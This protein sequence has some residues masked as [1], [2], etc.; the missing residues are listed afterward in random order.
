MNRSLSFIYLILISFNLFSMDPSTSSLQESTAFQKDLNRILEKVWKA[1]EKYPGAYTKSQD[2]SKII[3]THH[4]GPDAWF[5]LYET[6]WQILNPLPDEPPAR[7]VT[8]RTTVDPN[9]III[10]PVSRH[11]ETERSRHAEDTSDIPPNVLYLSERLSDFEGQHKGKT[12]ERSSVIRRA[13]NTIKAHPEMASDFSPLSD[14]RRQ[15]LDEVS[16]SAHK[17]KFGSETRA[18]PPAH[19]SHRLQSLTIQPTPSI[20]HTPTATVVP[21]ATNPFPRPAP[22]QLQGSAMKPKPQVIRRPT[23]SS[24]GTE[25]TRT[26]EPSVSMT[27]APLSGTPEPEPVIVG[28]QCLAAG[29]W[30]VC[31]NFSPAFREKYP[32]FQQLFESQTMIRNGMTLSANESRQSLLELVTLI[33]QEPAHINPSVNFHFD[34][35]AFQQQLGI[36]LNQL[37]SK[38]WRSRSITPEN[39]RQTI[40]DMIAR[41]NDPESTHAIFL[42]YSEAT[43]DTGF[44]LVLIHSQSYWFLVSTMTGLHVIPIPPQMPGTTSSTQTSNGHYIFRLIRDLLRQIQPLY[45]AEDSQ[46][47]IKLILTWAGFVSRPPSYNAQRMNDFDD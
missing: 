43:S 7:E 9:V 6:A 28:W 31:A 21:Q 35:A 5:K 26:I 41:L 25:E 8:T 10:P 13:R 23:L 3:S 2:L 1:R 18:R 24:A 46:D 44:T 20:P 38:Q 15:Q 39:K 11:S 27:E 45:F 4:S 12:I 22:E 30:D 42:D 34:V 29:F 40:D 16:W 17:R 36:I 37:H 33:L 14:S 19:I 32:D 47:P